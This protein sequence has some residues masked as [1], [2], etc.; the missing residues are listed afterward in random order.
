MGIA[1]D[2]M[3]GGSPSTR[4]PEQRKERGAARDLSGAK[5]KAV[6]LGA[7]ANVQPLGAACG[8]VLHFGPTNP[9]VA[10]LTR[11]FLE[12]LPQLI[13]RLAGVEELANEANGVLVGAE[14]VGIARSS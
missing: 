14:R 5:M 3:S 13:E 4:D 6:L 2:L 12:P 9:L 10:G 1:P 7:A 11:P 8:K